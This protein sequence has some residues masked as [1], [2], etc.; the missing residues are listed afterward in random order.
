MQVRHH[1]G[2]QRGEAVEVVVAVV[3]VVDDADVG[4]ALRLEP[5]DDRDLVLRLAEPA[6]VVVKGQRAADLAGLLGQR[7]EL[8][9][10]RL[11]P[12][13]LLGAR[14]RDRRPGRAGPRAAA[15]IPCR[16]SRSRMIRDSRLSSPGAT[17]KASSAM[18]CRLSAST[19][20]S[21]VG[22]CSARQS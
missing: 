19:S 8:G 21:K 15:L 12:P 17:Q 18:P 14:A 11:D 2:E 13:L 22:M 4:D 7:A 20:A 5:L 6:A 16:L 10:G 9:R 1:L 3:Q